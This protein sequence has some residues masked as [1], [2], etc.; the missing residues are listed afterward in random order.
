MVIVKGH[1]F[2]KNIQ[3]QKISHLLIV[4]CASVFIIGCAP[5]NNQNSQEKPSEANSLDVLQ[6]TDRYYSLKRGQVAASTWTFS[7]QLSTGVLKTSSVTADSITFNWDKVTNA[8]EYLLVRWNFTSSAWDL[9]GVTTNTQF[10]DGNLSAKTLYIY[11]VMPLN[12][13]QFLYGFSNGNLQVFTSDSLPPLPSAPIITAATTST[14]TTTKPS[15]TTTST[16]TTSTTTT[17]K[18]TTTTQSTTTTTVASGFSSFSSYIRSR[19]NN[20]LGRWAFSYTIIYNFVD[21]YNVTQYYQYDSTSI[22]FTG[23]DEYGFSI[24]ASYWY[25]DDDYSLL[26]TGVIID[27]FFYFNINGSNEGSG[28]YYQIDSSTKSWSRCYSLYGIRY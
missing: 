1:G 16:S 9:W 5:E 19:A 15:T 25:I 10:T 26:D 20:L 22:K 18:I 4:L 14:T 23:T 27:R 17:T 2:L 6:I 24:L 12:R 28:C 11:V 3:K 21:Y 7:D 8:E 13:S